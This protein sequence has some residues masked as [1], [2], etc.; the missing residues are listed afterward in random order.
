M[1]STHE[2]SPPALLQFPLKLATG[3][4]ALG[5]KVRLGAI[6]GTFTVLGKLA[7]KAHAE[8]RTNCDMC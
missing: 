3:K 8:H 6:L 2:L 4:L 5:P 7:E 1:R